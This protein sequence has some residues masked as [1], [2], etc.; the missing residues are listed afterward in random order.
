MNRTAERNQRKMTFEPYMFAASFLALLLKAA[1]SLRHDTKILDWVM[2][3]FVVVFVVTSI[4]FGLAMFSTRP[5]RNVVAAISTGAVTDS[6]VTGAHVKK[7]GNADVKV[8]TK[9]VT[10]SEVIGYREGEQ[11]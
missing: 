7:P 9:D 4:L 5:S 10:N 8:A 2:A 11:E 3:C 6:S 1:Y